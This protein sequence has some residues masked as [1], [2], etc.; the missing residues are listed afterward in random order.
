MDDTSKDSNEPLEEELCGGDPGAKL[1][2]WHE[3]YEGLSEDEIA[4]VEAMALDRSRSF[5]EDSE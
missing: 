5:R 4:E 3:V 1:A 2:A